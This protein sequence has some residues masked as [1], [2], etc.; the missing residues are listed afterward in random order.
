[1][2]DDHPRRRTDLGVRVVDDETLVLDRVGGRIHQLNTTASFIWQRCD[3]QRTI[4][5]IVDDLAHTFDVDADTARDA[6]MTSVRRF[7]ELGLLQDEDGS[8][9]A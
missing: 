8:P 6:V 4:H 5:E 3:G 2:V 7:T 9:R 1:M